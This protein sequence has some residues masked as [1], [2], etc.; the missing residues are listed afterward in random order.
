MGFIPKMAWFDNPIIGFSEED[1]QRL[2]HPHDNTLIVSIWV[3]DYNTHLIVVDN[4]STADIL[5]Y[6]TFQQMRIDRKRLVPTNALLVGFEGTKVYPLGVVTLPI[7]VGDY[8]E[9]ITKDVTF[10]VVDCSS[11]YTAILGQP[12]LSSWK[13]ETLIYHLMIKFPIE[14][15]LGEVHGD[16]MAARKCYIAML[17]M[18]NY[19]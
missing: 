13:A 10:L 14:Y 19:L 3:G 18:D 8:P 11:T 6:S 17:E 1:A 7:T 9:Q 5:Y 4:R 12:T 15:G 16:Q 2:H